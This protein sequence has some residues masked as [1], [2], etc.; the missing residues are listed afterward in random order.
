MVKWAPA[1]GIAEDVLR[2]K[3]QLKNSDNESCYLDVIA[4]L[5]KM[6]IDREMLKSTGI[7]KVVN[8]VSRKAEDVRVREAAALVSKWRKSVS[9]KVKASPK[10]SATPAS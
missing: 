2:L 5:G 10:P 8:S 6:P 7:G 3:R 9:S 4:A 1:A